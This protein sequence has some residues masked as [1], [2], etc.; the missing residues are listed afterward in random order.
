[1]HF[2]CVWKEYIVLK[3]HKQ[4]R[5][6]CLSLYICDV[7]SLS[8]YIEIQK[9][10]IRTINWV[11]HCFFLIF[12]TNVYTFSNDHELNWLPTLGFSWEEAFSTST[13]IL[14]GKVP[15]EI[16]RPQREIMQKLISVFIIKTR[17]D[18][19]NIREIVNVKVTLHRSIPFIH[20]FLNQTIEYLLMRIQECIIL[21]SR[22][23]L[24]S[25]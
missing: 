5:F 24:T 10:M 20:V 4:I 13:S 18:I 1:M 16:F 15:L 9:Y 17:I 21:V 7:A 25:F 12:A 19:K 22:I 2:K 3:L 14:F 8:I 6:T 23:K 11:V